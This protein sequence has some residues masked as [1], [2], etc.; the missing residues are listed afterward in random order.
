MP[1][2]PTLVALSPAKGFVGTSLSVT[3]TGANFI[4]NGTKVLIDGGGI[5]VKSVSVSTPTT[6]L[7]TLNIESTAAT[8]DRKVTVSTA[9]GVS[10]AKTFTVQVSPTQTTLNSSSNPSVFGETVTF[11]AAV[12]TTSGGTPSG[13]IQF[14]DGAT[15]ITTA[16]LSNGQAK[17]NNSAL[18]VGPHSITAV[19]S[20]NSS[21]EGST[22]PVLTQTVNKSGVTTLVT[23]SVNPATFGQFLILTSTVAAGANGNGTPP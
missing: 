20:G 6:L 11:T 21:F 8:G 9:G 10:A 5:T 17:F 2:V 7:A 12:S 15:T 14:K 19:Y 3:L 16:E 22:S 13:S 4:N 1:P 18:P 23:S